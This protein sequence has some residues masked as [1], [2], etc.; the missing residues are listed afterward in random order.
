VAIGGSM[1]GL[2]AAAFLRKIS[3]NV[4]VHERSS[5]ELVGRGVG[6]TR[7]RRRILAA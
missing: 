2:L 5:I 1:S 7:S 6:S 4:K 3:W